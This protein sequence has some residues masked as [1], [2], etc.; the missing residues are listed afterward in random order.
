[1]DNPIPAVIFAGGQSRRMGRDKALVDF[2]GKSLAKYQ[3]DR[4]KE[5]FGEVYI[6]T[7]VDKFDFDAPLILDRSQIFGPAPAFLE[8]FRKLGRSFFAISVDTPFIGEEIIR[9]LV[10]R[11]MEAREG[12][13]VIARTGE[14]IHPLIGVYHPSILPHFEESIGKGEYRLQTILRGAEIQYLP[15]PQKEEQFFNI[16]YPEELE[17]AL[18]LLRQRGEGS[19]S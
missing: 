7:K 13:G 15:F 6:S 16:N 19:L 4:L 10:K 17:T 18:A 1:M 3:Y 9:E 5:L 11:G 12:D 14:R 8:I 2:G